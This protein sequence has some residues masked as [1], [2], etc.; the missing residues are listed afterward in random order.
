MPLSNA[1]RLADFGTG[2]GTQGAILQVDNANARFGVGTTAPAAMQ[3]VG[4]AI[5]MY[6]TSGI[7][8]ATQFYGDGSKL[9]GVSGAGL[10]TAIT[11]SNPGNVLYYTTDILSVGSTVTVDTP[12]GAVPA[13]TQYQDIAVET[14]ADLIIETDTDFIPDVLN[15]SN[16]DASTDG[17]SGGRVRADS[18]VN[19]GATGAPSFPL[20][21]VVT[22]VI[23]A[24]T[25]S[26]SGDVSIG[27]TL[28][29]EDVKN[30]DSVGLIT[31]RSGIEVSGIVTAM[32][33][34]AVTYYGDG[35][36][37]SGLAA[38]GTVNDITSSLFI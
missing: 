34:A 16:Y 19:R 2:I 3:Q 6:G 38:S 9:T 17:V 29:Y 12:A 30:V 22:G 1:S 13:Y 11:E 14:D 24:T 4:T 20:G 37:L 28:T 15:L 36:N 31:A 18:Y 26:F 35:S 25:G 8:S 7:V 21:A 32:A 33:G 5:T 10:G 23:T 27:G